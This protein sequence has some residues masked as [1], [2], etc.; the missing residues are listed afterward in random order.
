MFFISEV[1]A[2][3]QSTVNE[4]IYKKLVEKTLTDTFVE[5]KMAELRQEKGL[6]IYDTF[7]EKQY[8]SS[9]KTYNVTHET[10]KK[11][12]ENL[13]AIVE[14]HEYTTDQLFDAMDKIYGISLAITL[15]NEE[16]FL[17][18]T[19]YNKYFDT[20]MLIKKR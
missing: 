11:A 6:V 12:S 8:V 4:E 17:V 19:N 5:T 9:A 7:L 18:N 10:T 2:P 13:V 20:T 3:E 14:G 16:R 15:I 1:A